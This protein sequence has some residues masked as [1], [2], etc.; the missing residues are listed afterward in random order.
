MDNYGY[1]KI[2]NVFNKN[3]SMLATPVN[4]KKGFIEI[5]KEIGLGMEIDEAKIESESIIK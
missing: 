3:K 4:P 1:K 5:P 2:N